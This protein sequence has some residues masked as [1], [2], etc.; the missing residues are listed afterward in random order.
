MK[1]NFPIKKTFEQDFLNIKW[2]TIFTIKYDQ[3]T[4]LEYYEYINKS[5]EEQTIELY[6]ILKKFIKYSL[7]DKILM[8][9]NKNYVNK[10]ERWL[11]ISEILVSIFQNRYRIY[12]SIFKWIRKV[13]K[14]NKWAIDSAWLSNICKTYNISP[15]DLMKNYTLEQYFWFLDWI[16]WINNS[17]DKEWQFINN[18]AIVDR[19]AIKKRA[20]ETKQKFN[21]FKK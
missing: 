3:A 5:Q 12:E 6:N 21:N 20:E 8:F 4:I 7:K 19:E 2:D 9:L 13:D 1:T 15:T 16:E 18:L 17:M 10:I 14:K 11:K